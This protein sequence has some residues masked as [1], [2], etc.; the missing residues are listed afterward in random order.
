MD[1]IKKIKID[2]EVIY[3]FN[4]LDET[5]KD[6]IVKRFYKGTSFGVSLE[7]LYAIIDLE[8]ECIHLRRLHGAISKNLKQLD[9][10]LVEVA[11]IMGKKF[12]TGN[13]DGSPKGLL[14][15]AKQLGYTKQENFEVMKAV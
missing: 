1:E 8:F 12:V 4:H 3:K 9:L 10:F 6:E 2:N 7:G 11:K 13:Y 5:E 15:F 14:R